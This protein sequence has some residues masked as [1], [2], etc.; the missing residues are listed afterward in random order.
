MPPMPAAGTRPIAKGGPGQPTSSPRSIEGIL[1]SV[2]RRLVPALALAAVAILA[3]GVLI[4]QLLPPRRTTPVFEPPVL[5]GRPLWGSCAGG[6]HARRGE[7]VVVTS[8]GHCAAEGT[9]AYRWQADERD[10]AMP[11]RVGTE[12]RWQTIT[13]TTDWKVMAN[14]VPKE[15][16]AVATDYYYVNV[17]KQ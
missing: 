14:T 9:V 10:F 7:T 5:A 16:F 15:E 2:N 6:F 3:A 13:P 12:G 4:A 11:I 17:M 8:S 1:R